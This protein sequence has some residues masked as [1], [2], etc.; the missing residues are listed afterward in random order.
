MKS[1]DHHS[2][3]PQGNKPGLV[4]IELDTEQHLFDWLV[5]G[6]VATQIQERVTIQCSLCSVQRRCVFSILFTRQRRSHSYATA[7]W[8][9]HQLTAASNQN[10]CL[11]FSVLPP[12]LYLS[13]TCLLPSRRNLFWK[14]ASCAIFVFFKNVLF[15][16]LCMMIFSTSSFLFFATEEESRFSKIRKLFQNLKT[17]FPG[18]I[19]DHLHPQFQHASFKFNQI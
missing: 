19:T 12:F 7:I 10:K 8:P 2:V 5:V 6:A 16:I 18:Q 11:S 13:Y 9:S 17:I 3:S 4:G 14:F 15:K 1:T